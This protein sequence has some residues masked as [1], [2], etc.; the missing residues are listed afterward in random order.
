M[1]TELTGGGRGLPPPDL[2]GGGGSLLCGILGP[3]MNTE[4]IKH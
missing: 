2:D 3:E 4:T 1:P